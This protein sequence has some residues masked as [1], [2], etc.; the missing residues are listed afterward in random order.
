MQAAGADTADVFVSLTSRSQSCI[1]TYDALKQLG[2]TPTVVTTG[3]CFG[4]PMTDHL[5]DARRVRAPCPTAGTSATTATTTTCPIYES[6]MHT[7]VTKV[8]QYGVK[9]P[10]AKTLEYTG[11][12]GPM[13]ANLLTVVK[14]VQR[15]RRRQ[16]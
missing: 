10:G 2:I 11:F 7:Y 14:F 15:D 16:R 8:Q 6:G 9:A 12:A 3:L 4:T 5:H 1:A 13:F